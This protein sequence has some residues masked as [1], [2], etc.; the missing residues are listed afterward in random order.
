MFG[1]GSGG[2]IP[3]QNT[4]KIIELL[5]AGKKPTEVI[6]E[7]FPAT[8][9]WRR[10]K[11]LKE[12]PHAGEKYLEKLK[13]RARGG[14]K[15]NGLGELEPK[16][17]GNLAAG[18]GQPVLFYRVKA[19]VY[20]G[21]ISDYVNHF[22]R[23]GFQLRSYKLTKVYDPETAKKLAEEIKAFIFQPS[24]LLQSPTPSTW[25]QHQVEPASWGAAA[26]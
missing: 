21:N 12:D 15:G 18:L 1:S 2:G 9:V 24:H 23:E 10:S 13:A 26:R 8:T 11:K 4:A 20:E 17:D 5:L 16:A 25:G 7:R 22:C 6:A 14:D 19:G 3:N